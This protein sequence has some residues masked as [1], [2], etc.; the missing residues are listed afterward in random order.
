MDKFK[1]SKFTALLAALCLL[2]VGVAQNPVSVSA[3]ETASPRLTVDINRNDGRKASYSR[4]A[5]NWIING[6][7]SAS[8]EIGG[9][10][11]TLST[12][13]E[14]CILN[15]NNNKKLQKMSGIYPRLTMDGVTAS[16]PFTIPST[17]EISGVLQ[18]EI[19]GLSAGTHTL[20][21][22]HASCQSSYPAGTLR[23]SVNGQ[24][25]AENVP[26]PLN[27]SDE[28]DA[29]IA[30]SVFEVAEGET[31][32]VLIE[33]EGE[34]NAWLNAFEIDGSDPIR[35]ISRITPEHMD[36]HHDA[37]EGLSW[38]AGVDAVSHDVYFGTNETAVYNATTDSPEFK[39][40]Q[41]HTSYA[42]NPGLSA[43]PTYYWR[44]D[45]IDSEGNVH[46][47]NVNAF[48]LNRLAFPTAEGYGRFAA[49]GRGGQVVHT[50]SLNDDVNE[51]GTLR[52]AIENEIWQT[53]DWMGVP[54]I[55]V[56]DVGGIIVL[57]DDLCIP[58]KGGSVYIAGQ[59]APGDGIT[60]INYSFGA[61]G[62]QDVII[63]DVRLRVGDMNGRS[64]GGMGLAS[65]DHSI[66]DHCSMSWATDDG[67][68]SRSA[69][70]ITFQWNIIAE[71]IDEYG[72]GCLGGTVEVDSFG[73]SIGGYTGS[74]H[75][76][77]VT[78]C[79]ARNWSL[80]GG[81]E[82]DA[83]T[84]GGQADIRN[85]VVYNWYDRTTDNGMWRV[86]FVNNYYKA[87]P[88]SITDIHLVSVDGN[89]LGTNDM[90]MLYA[91]GNMM[92]NQDGTILLAAEADE[93]ESGKAVCGEKNATEADIRS[94]EPFFEP[95]VNTETAEEAYASV[96]A[97]AGAGGTTGRDY[98][99]SR[100]IDEVT[101]GTATYSGSITEIMGIPN[102]M[103]DV[104]GYP[105]AETFL[106]S[107]DGMTNAENDTDRD[108]MPNVWEEA[109]GLNPD[110]PTDGAIVSLSAEDYTNVE[111]YLNELMGDPV[112][113][114]TNVAGDVNADG[115]FSVADV[116]MLQKWLLNAG[117]LP[118]WEVADLCEDGRIDVFDLVVMKREILKIN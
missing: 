51:E 24:T 59:T 86:N 71:S 84:Y 89:E 1:L 35:G 20:K 113:Y 28:D 33:P 62:A 85:N 15:T 109:H 12:E 117:S 87:G 6:E 81:M 32:T 98:I 93:W 37:E 94:D 68:S 4:N 97:H 83:I 10:T 34:C 92:V 100:Y 36:C 76:N 60:L 41:K 91:S 99:D 70:N 18:L 66:I 107:T 64:T 2:T 57:K 13:T 55:I 72:S 103:A 65:C 45:T 116:V 7:T 48:R 118:N 16:V 114:R 111:M 90:Q 27:P 3:E 88:A 21:T 108:G 56:F 39:G 54:R 49:G 44:V 22:W 58:D 14:G 8:A 61:M 67:F 43:I 74:Y 53:D 106:H 25:T 73:A 77:L 105:T 11:F 82:Q 17:E 42:L 96:L 31:V 110:D 102:T 23:I 9:L 29:G 40:N 19:A 112:V 75:H 38:T 30:Y 101:N 46:K 95:F 63:R 26:C 47:G 52:W 79:S 5:E 80:A 104:G 69:R 50:T 115:S 78:N